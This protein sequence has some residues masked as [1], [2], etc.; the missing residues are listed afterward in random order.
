MIGKATLVRGYCVLVLDRIP[1]VDATWLTTRFGKYA[2]ADWVGRKWP[3]G[4]KPHER[5]AELL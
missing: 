1:V 5:R 4:G 2:R 3:A